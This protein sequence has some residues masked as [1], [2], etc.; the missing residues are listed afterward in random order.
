M[1]FPEKLSRIRSLISERDAIDDQLREL[2]GETATDRPK[3]GRPRKEKGDSDSEPP[4]LSLSE[5]QS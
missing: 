4:E 3:R 5:P 1:Y 2:I